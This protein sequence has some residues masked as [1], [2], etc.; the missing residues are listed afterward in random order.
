MKLKMLIHAP[1]TMA[2]MEKSDFTQ[3]LLMVK[4]V[5]EKLI[6][7]LGILIINKQKV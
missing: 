6:L 3:F 1:M 4:Q 5:L 7:W 2:P